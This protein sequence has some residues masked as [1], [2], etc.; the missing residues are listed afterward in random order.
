MNKKIKNILISILLLSVS[1]LV[2][3]GDVN[4]DP[5]ERKVLD[6]AAKL[7]CTVC[8]NQ[9]VAESNSGLARDMRAVIK[10]KLQEGKNEQEIVKFFVDRYGDYV[11]L[12]PPQSGN[13][14]PLWVFPPLFLLLAIIAVILIMKS[15]SEKVVATPPSALSVEDQERIRLAREAMNKSGEDE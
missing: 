3:S 15:R 5:L 6:I 1:S 13:G 2:F 7:R 11:L 14:I 9:P 12:S 10:E 8:Q 4:E